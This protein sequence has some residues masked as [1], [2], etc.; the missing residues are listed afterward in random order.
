MTLGWVDRVVILVGFNAIS[1][2][3]MTVFSSGV[4]IDAMAKA[5]R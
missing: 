3:L 1:F 5:A 4:S 2:A